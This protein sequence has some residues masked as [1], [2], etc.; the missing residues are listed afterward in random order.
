MKHPEQMTPLKLNHLD[1]LLKSVSGKI[2][3]SLK[4]VTIR[5][6]TIGYKQFETKLIFYDMHMNEVS[7]TSD[8]TEAER[9][10][11]GDFCLTDYLYNNLSGYGNPPTGIEKFSS[12][13]DEKIHT[14]ATFIH[15]VSL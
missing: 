5:L 6:E 8:F 12:E 15:D 13:F 14:G 1:I 11:Y 4:F 9:L 7:V 2:P 3:E 10:H